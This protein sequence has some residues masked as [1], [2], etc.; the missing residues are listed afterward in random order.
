VH[1]SDD[2]GRITMYEYRTVGWDNSPQ[3]LMRYIYSNNL[4]SAM[5]E[6]DDNGN[7][8]SYEEYHPFGTTA[9]QATNASI[10]AVAKRYRY[11]GK[12]RDEESGLY[13]HGARYY[14]PW[15]CRWTQCDP[16]G[17]KDGLNVYAYVS[18]N[19]VIY[20]DPS[21]KNKNKNKQKEPENKQN[22]NSKK[23]N[24]KYQ[25]KWSEGSSQEKKPVKLATGTPYVHATD[26][27]GSSNTATKKE[28]KK[29]LLTPPATTPVVDNTAVK[30]VIQPLGEPIPVN[31]NIPASAYPSQE[32]LNA[33][34]NNQTQVSQSQFRPNIRPTFMQAWANAA[35][36]NPDGAA[37]F[38]IV[39]PPVAVATAAA[40]PE[41]GRRIGLSL[42][43]TNFLAGGLSAASDV[44]SQLVTN[45]GDYTKINPI[46]T[47]SAGLLHKYPVAAAIPGVIFESSIQ[48]GLMPKITQKS[49]TQVLTE[50]TLGAAGNK[51]GD[52]S[53]AYLLKGVASPQLYQKTAN[54][55]V[56]YGGQLVG[57]LSSGIVTKS[58]DTLFKKP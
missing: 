34:A 15:L 43:Q 6:L 26:S 18:N 44:T 10:N 51:L 28:I 37:A 33:S 56:G 49:T 58:I 19:P 17:I 13:Y 48:E 9:Y 5:L 52:V 54:S 21:G 38:M 41:V 36:T 30:T 47:I 32:L 24:E 57:D 11:T 12:E 55:I 25:Y 53:E 46:S 4:S 14:I 31:P 7:I 35:K 27:G 45:K 3:E 22:S 8:I 1:I 42:T 20:H 50:I 16:I 2:T 39:A 29:E 23:S 40:V